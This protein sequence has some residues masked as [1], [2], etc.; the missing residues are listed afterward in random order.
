MVIHRI[1]NLNYKFLFVLFGLLFLSFATLTTYFNYVFVDA[2]EYHQDFI[3]PSVLNQYN[4]SILY[5]VTIIFSRIAMF[6]IL[7]GLMKITIRFMIL[8][9]IKSIGIDVIE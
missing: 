5:V 7:M 8:K 4:I 6:C 9:N 1:V 2:M 3:V